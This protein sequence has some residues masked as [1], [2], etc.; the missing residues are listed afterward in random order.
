MTQTYL[1]K[2]YVK[3]TSSSWTKALFTGLP[4]LGALALPV[5]TAINNEFDTKIQTD[6]LATALKY[7][8]PIEYDSAKSFT[9][10]GNLSH[11]GVSVV[12]LELI[13]Q[14]IHSAKNL[15]TKYN[16]GTQKVLKVKLPNEVAT[17]EIIAKGSLPISTYLGDLFMIGGTAG[18]LSTQDPLAKAGFAIGGV[19]GNIICKSISDD[20]CYEAS[21]SGGT[22]IVN[23]NINS[24]NNTFIF[25]NGNN[26]STSSNEQISDE[27]AAAMLIIMGIV[28]TYAVSKMLID[29]SIP[30]HYKYSFHNLNGKEIP[31]TLEWDQNGDHHIS[32]QYGREIEVQ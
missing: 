9:S 19:L 5:A 31:L 29:D 18:Y 14:S 26:Y 1:K 25:N 20:S 2:N 22:N 12:S 27:A 28:G 3:S 7:I 11:I 21:S 4:I 16:Q 23:S 30:G 15:Y 13:S 8:N 32:D 17:K 24:N 6:P 10:T